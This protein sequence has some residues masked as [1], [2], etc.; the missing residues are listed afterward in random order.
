MTVTQ[1]NMTKMPERNAQKNDFSAALARK[2]E[3]VS[4]AI[5][6]VLENPPM[7]RLGC[8]KLLGDSPIPDQLDAAIRYTLGA[9]G[10]LLRG[11]LV[12]ICCQLIEGKINPDAETAAAAVELIHTYSLV[13]DDLPA[14][15]DDDMR[16]GQP[17]CHKAFGEAAAILT[18]DALLTMA[19]EIIAKSVSSP[20]KAVKL[21][22]ILSSAAGP[23]GMIA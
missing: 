13:H 8:A 5:A 17:T 6:W 23:G 1:L 19:F 11:S 3:Q 21:I 15:D 7:G 20:A 4:K 12:L 14:M 2:A 10:K 9:P 16:R 22:D 18:G